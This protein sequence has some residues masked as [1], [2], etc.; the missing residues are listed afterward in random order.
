MPKFEFVNHSCVIL[1]HNNVSLAM[2]PWFE[3]SVFNNSWDLLSKTPKKSIVS[4]KKSNFIWFSH[5]HPDHFNPPNLKIFSD[6]NNF[7]FQKTID[8]RV[9]KFLRKISPHVNEINFKDTFKLTKDFTI[10]VIPFQYLDSMSII[11]INNLTI[12]NLNDCDIKN[13]FQLKF[14]KDLTGPIDVLLVQFSYAIGKSNKLNKDQ[15][16]KWSIEIL[17]KLSYVIKFLK[18]KTVIPFASFCYFSKLDNFYM[19]DSSN[20]IDKTIEYLSKENPDVKFLCFYPGDTWDFHSNV[21]NLNSFNKYNKDY[22]KIDILPYYEKRIDFDILKNSSNKF[23]ETINRN[24]NLFY[25][26]KF[27]N[28]NNYKIFFKLKDLNKTFFFD[29]TNG[30][31]EINDFT[32]NQPWCS[33]TSQSLNN[34]FTSGY[35]YDALI[36]GGRFESNKLGLN[37]LN[38][39]FKFQ[40]KNYQNIYY[41]ID[42]ILNNFLKKIFKT[43][44]IFHNRQL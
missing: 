37:S 7:L 16:Q 39:I 13:D 10:Q 5:E 32:S 9:V 26:Y 2:D 17:K 36:I 20:K 19:N 11:K 18:P 8:G 12:L 21:S 6:K 41:N 30:L 42:S 31:V 4:L 34:L 3:G 14:I 1:S 38:K 23:I 24:N 15:R 25:F 43:S 40:A 33:L 22:Q 29:F 44:K 35:G 28:K 27:L